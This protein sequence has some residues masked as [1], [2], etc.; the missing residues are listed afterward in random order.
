MAEQ[1]KPPESTKPWIELCEQAA[2]EQDS[3]KLIR[4]VQAISTMLEENERKAH[5]KLRADNA[6]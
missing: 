2:V 3:E 1:S 6:D 4:L 5:A